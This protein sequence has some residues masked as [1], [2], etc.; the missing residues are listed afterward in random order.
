MLVLGRL[1]IWTAQTSG[2]TKR[3]WAWKPFLTE[4]GR[5]D[6]CLGF[7]VFLILAAI[8]KV[9]VLEPDY[10]PFVSEF[11]TAIAVSFGVHL[12][13]IGWTM[14]YGVIELTED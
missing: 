8:M 2:P 6:F 13:R 5:C 11:V 7:W 12:A 14:Q 1:V 3:L 9:N 4:L 10:Y